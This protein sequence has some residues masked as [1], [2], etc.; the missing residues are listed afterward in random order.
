MDFCWVFDGFLMDFC[1][2]FDGFL[3]DFAVSSVVVEAARGRA[4]SSR[5][6][7]F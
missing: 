1:W 5:M 3:V 4:W 2:V 7:G 6:V